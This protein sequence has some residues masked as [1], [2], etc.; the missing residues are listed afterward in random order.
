MSGGSP[1]NNRE[2]NLVCI[3]SLLHVSHTPPNYL[4]NLEMRTQASVERNQAKSF[5]RLRFPPGVLRQAVGLQMQKNLEAHFSSA[6]FQKFSS[7]LG[8]QWPAGLVQAWFVA[9]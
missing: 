5:L 8:L 4:T 2:A 1:R 3:G 7:F 6:S 9:L